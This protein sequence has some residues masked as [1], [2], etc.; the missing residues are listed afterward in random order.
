MDTNTTNDVSNLA[1]QD[2]RGRGGRFL[3]HQPDLAEV[4]PVQPSVKFSG[5]K[6]FSSACRRAVGP[7]PA[8]AGAVLSCENPVTVLPLGSLRSGSPYHGRRMAGPAV[9]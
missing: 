9:D 6:E 5:S 3:N 8:V 7:P 2:A 1:G 4:F